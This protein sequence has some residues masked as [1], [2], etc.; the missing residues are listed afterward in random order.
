MANGLNNP[1]VKFENYKDRYK[2]I[3]LERKDGILLVTLHTRGGPFL[4]SDV[5]HTDSC[6]AFANIAADFENKCVI[7]TG[8]GDNFCTGMEFNADIS[9]PNVLARIQWEGR[10]M[11][12]NLTDIEVPVIGAVNG[13]AFIHA[14]MGVMHDIVICTEDTVFQDLPHFP[15]G[16]VPGDGVHVIWQHILGP[17]RGRYFLLSG[18]KIPAQEAKD[19]GIVNE[20]VPRAR[21][22]D[23]AWELAEMITKNSN[24]VNRYSRLVLTRNYRKLLEAETGYGLSLEL[25]AATVRMKEMMG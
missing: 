25:F 12:L 8:T 19:V 1:H 13:P 7:V 6:D 9:D 4:F 16:T 18:Q 22:M 24:L 17:T 5:F 3:R 14:E 23:R 2:N 11:L 15:S 20:V 21:L 10:K